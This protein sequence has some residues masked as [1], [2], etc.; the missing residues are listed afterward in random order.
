MRTAQG[1]TP[2]HLVGRF[3]VRLTGQI[4]YL[5]KYL[6]FISPPDLLYL[7]PCIPLGAP[8]SFPS[9]V[10]RGPG[11]KFLSKRQ[12]SISCDRI[13]SLGQIFVSRDTILSPDRGYI[14]IQEAEFCLRDKILSPGTDFCLP[15]YL[16]CLRTGDGLFVPETEFCPRDRILC[17][18]V[19]THKVGHTPRDKK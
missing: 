13:L 2:L 11:D 19:R 3:V 4:R 14:S 12:N 10:L 7:Y 16:L 15:G 8:G 6:F 1:R 17:L 9:R 18:R 5:R